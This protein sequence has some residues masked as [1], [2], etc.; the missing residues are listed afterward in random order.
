MD[1]DAG[2]SGQLE[3]LRSALAASTRRDSQARIAEAHRRAEAILGEARG[4]ARKITESATAEGDAV[5]QRQGA[6]R[7]VEAKRSARGQVLGAQ[8]RAYELLVESSL[9]SL[10]DSAADDE[11]TALQARLVE[12]ARDTLGTDVIVEHDPDGPGGIEARSGTRRMDLS[13]GE[14]VRRC[15][16]KMGK[17]VSGL[18]E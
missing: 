9:R 8:R 4:R 10:R 6:R 13:L 7:L 1:G 18:W 17:A 5:A 2:L 12:I 14:I 16:E 15:V 11:R 3:P